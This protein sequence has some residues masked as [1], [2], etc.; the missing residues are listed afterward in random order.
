VKPN[1]IGNNT[2]PIYAFFTILRRVV[3]FI[4]K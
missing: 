2:L 1:A 4:V 3:F